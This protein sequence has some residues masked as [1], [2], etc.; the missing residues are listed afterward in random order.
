MT[1]DKKITRNMPALKVLDM[2]AKRIDNH[3]GTSVDFTCDEHGRLSVAVSKTES[4]L[5][6]SKVL[7]LNKAIMDALCTV[8]R[9]AA[10]Q[11]LDAVAAFEK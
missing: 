7:V 8:D 3:S 6:A 9:M 5:N 11:L 2:T 10:G 1:K 4:L